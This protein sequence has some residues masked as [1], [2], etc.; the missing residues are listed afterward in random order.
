MIRIYFTCYLCL[1][2]AVERS[3]LRKIAVLVFCYVVGEVYLVCRGKKNVKRS[4]VKF[5]NE[6]V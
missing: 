3:N 2:E 4:F 1:R 6:M 5:E